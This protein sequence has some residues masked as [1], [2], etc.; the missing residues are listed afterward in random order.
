MK[1][2][3]PSCPWCPTT[4]QAW[5]QAQSEIRVSRLRKLG[6]YAPPAG[7]A[8]RDDS[9]MRGI[10]SRMAI[11]EP[12]PH[13]GSSRLEEI[14]GFAMRMGYKK[15]GVANC[16]GFGD[17]AQA[18]CGILES[19]GFEVVS[20]A[21]KHAGMRDD[22]PW[23]PGY[24]KIDGG[25]LDSVCYPIAQAALLNACGAEFN[26]ALGLCVGCDCQFFKHATAPISVLLVKDRMLH[27]T[28]GP[29]LQLAES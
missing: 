19:R 3:T 23:L 12:S 20:A 10:V 8:L 9:K 16:V 26:V 15:I 2:D 13:G 29:A 11:A 22:E 1:T 14:I 24:E 27:Q 28:S 6:L 7:R 4:I 21:G 5:R 18:L 25:E 17:F